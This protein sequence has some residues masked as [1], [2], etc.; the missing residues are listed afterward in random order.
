MPAKLPVEIREKI[1]ELY[2]NNIMITKIAEL[3]DR[4]YP[5]ITYILK[6]ECGYDNKRPNQGNINYFSTIDTYSKAYILGYIAAD[7]CIYKD[8]RTNL[9]RMSIVVNTK[10]IEFLQFVKSEIG[11]D[12]KI[13]TST[14]FDKRTNKY[15]NRSSLSLGNQTLCRTLIALGINENK[16]FTLENFLPVIPKQFRKA[17]ILGYFDGDG[18]IA[19]QVDKRVKNPDYRTYSIEICSTLSFLKGIVAEL[20]LAN[21]NITNFENYSILRIC[22]KSDFYKFYSCYENLEF[23]LKRKHNIFLQRINYERTISSSQ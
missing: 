23:Y 15:Y 9:Y 2:N 20:K 3:V 8:K 7:G 18:H 12:T 11:C 5:T 10:D 6:K 4:P 19:A 16:T 1:I 13:L 22:N 17:C 14:P 21:Y